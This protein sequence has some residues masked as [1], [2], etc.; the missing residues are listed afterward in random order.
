MQIGTALQLKLQTHTVSPPGHHLQCSLLHLR[1][2]S[3]MQP[4]TPHPK[5]FGWPPHQRIVLIITLQSTA[6]VSTWDYFKSCHTV[7]YSVRLRQLCI[8]VHSLV[9][10]PQVATKHVSCVQWQWCT[11]SRPS[12]RSAPQPMDHCHSGFGLNHWSNDRTHVRQQP[13]CRLANQT[14]YSWET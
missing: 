6:K 3:M 12:S 10:V 14:R 13:L 5:P 9:T 11:R 4:A 1:R 8:A 7:N 2:Q